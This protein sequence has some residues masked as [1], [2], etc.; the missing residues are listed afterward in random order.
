MKNWELVVANGMIHEI[1]IS[2]VY[3]ISD[4]ERELYKDKP[5]CVSFGGKGHRF[6]THEEAVEKT[7]EWLRKDA[8]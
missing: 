8:E 1:P 4:E 2:L 6:S 3:G 5:Y 7:V